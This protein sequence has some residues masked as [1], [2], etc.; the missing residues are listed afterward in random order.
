MWYNPI[1]VWLLRSPL[2]GFMSKNTMLITYTGRKS[3]KTY[4]TPVNYLVFSIGG[5][6]AYI[7]TSQRTRTWWRNFRQEAPVGLRVQGKDLKGIA[8]AIEDEA[9]VAEILRDYFKKAPQMGRYFG[10]H[11]QQNGEPNAEDIHVEAQ[12]RVIIKTVLL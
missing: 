6:R 8:I 7:T 12:K 11:I 10:V 1:I 3:G 5:E 4:T 9:R 2:H